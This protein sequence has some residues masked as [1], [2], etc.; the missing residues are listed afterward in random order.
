[1]NAGRRTCR[2]RYRSRPRRIV[3]RICIRRIDNRYWASH[4]STVHDAVFASLK[5]SEMSHETSDTSREHDASHGEHHGHDHDHDHEGSALSEMDLRVRAL[6][7]L[8]V[9]KGYVDPQ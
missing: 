8:L 6:E 2:G 5:E 3:R 7:S 1:M 4:P 9:E